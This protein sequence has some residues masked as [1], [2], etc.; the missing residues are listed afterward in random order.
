MHVLPRPDAMFL[1]D[2]PHLCQH[3]DHLDDPP[4]LHQENI[5]KEV[6]VRGL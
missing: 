4:H 6:L 5:Q 3:M 1:I 2:D